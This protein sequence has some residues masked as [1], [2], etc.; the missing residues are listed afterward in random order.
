MFRDLGP[1][2]VQLWSEV[3]HRTPQVINPLRKGPFDVPSGSPDPPL[4]SVKF[5]YRRSISRS[6][7]R[8]E[9]PRP[10]GGGLGFDFESRRKPVLSTISLRL[11]TKGGR[12]SPQ[13]LTRQKEL[14]TEKS[15]RVRGRT[16]TRPDD[17]LFYGLRETC[18]SKRFF[19]FLELESLLKNV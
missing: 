11:S 7:I 15:G 17:F 5:D 10:T 8:L 3:R 16:W 14:E 19:F 6:L 18:S 4:Q 1:F 12:R 9:T 2:V 13:R